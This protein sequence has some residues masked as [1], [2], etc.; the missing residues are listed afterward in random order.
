MIEIKNRRYIGCKTKLID[1]IYDIVEKNTTIKNY[2]FADLFA[3]T[4]VVSH[5]FLKN[6]HEVFVNDILYSNYIVYKA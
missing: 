4:G 5:F 6:G 1:I 2:T 3:G